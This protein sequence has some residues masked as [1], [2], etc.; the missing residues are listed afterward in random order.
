MLIMY[1]FIAHVTMKCEFPLDA[2]VT[3]PGTVI[4]SPNHPNAYEPYTDCRAT[5]TFTKRILLRFL[6][7]DIGE[8]E[9]C[10]DNL[11][12]YDESFGQIGPKL[13]NGANPTEIESIGNEIRIE[14][15]TDR[16][17]HRTGFQI[18]VLEIGRQIL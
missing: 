6:K 9:T 12:I 18:Q 15:Y 17:T 14:F 10:S 3:I 11:I 8:M 13:C 4:A 2:D 7:F 5:I 1:L 16:M